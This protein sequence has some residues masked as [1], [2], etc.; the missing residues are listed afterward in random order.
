MR[1]LEANPSSKMF[2]IKGVQG[3][4][5]FKNQRHFPRIVIDIVFLFFLGKHHRYHRWVARVVKAH[6]VL[7]H[8]LQETPLEPAVTIKPPHY[9]VFTV[10]NGFL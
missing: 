7:P 3:L 9:P 1:N 6:T 4:T 8:V 10:P 2:V 5:K